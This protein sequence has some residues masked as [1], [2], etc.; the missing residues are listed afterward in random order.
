M[1]KFY[2]RLALFLVVLL[3][4]PLGAFAQI[5]PDESTLVIAQTVDVVTFEPYQSSSRPEANIYSHVW[6]TLLSV[7]PDGDII[8][9]A[10]ESYTVSDDGTEYTFT[11]REGL[12]CHDGAPL[13][14]D[15]VVFS[16]QR[17][18]DPDNGFTGN[19]AGFV[20]NSLGYRDVRLDGELQATVILNGPQ[21]VA[22]GLFAEVYLIC[23]ESYE[24]LSLEEAA[25]RPIGS[26]PYRFV[27]WVP[28]DY[29]LLERYEDFSLEPG[30]FDRLVWRVIPE[31]STRVAELLAG[32]VDIVAN[33]PPDQVTVINNSGVA[34]AQ[35][36]AGTRRI[37]VGFSFNEEA[38]GDAPGFDAIQNT[39]VRIAMN[40][41]VDVPTICETLLSFSCERANGLVNPPNHNRNIEPYPY[42]PAR[43]EEILDAAGY[44]RGEDGV[45]FSITLQAPRGRYVNDANVA[46]A[47]GQYLSDVGIDTTVELIEWAE[48]VP[49][50][51]TQTAGPLF[52]LGTGGATW[53]AIYDMA[54]LSSV[55]G[56]TNYTQ[57]SNPEWFDN[58]PIML[59]A[60]G[61]EQ[62]ALIDYML[63]VFFNDPPWL[64]L[65]FQPDFYGVSNRI[66]WEARRDEKIDVR[67]ASLAQ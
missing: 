30:N 55:T 19:I 51:R 61:D 59:A 31:A 34:E 35:V 4:L 43:A 40:M 3:A 21:P 38:F 39:D 9:Y 63:E 13:T 6:I 7:T 36:V 54:D 29:L 44:P 58:W 66:D 46:L 28:D 33:V 60:T 32:N 45:R 16:F 42:D 65:Y 53:S 41:A 62:R 8:P 22:P 20:M 64:M 25:Q 56:S 26:G 10:A 27:E 14:A 52:F 47:I 23:R 37:Y 18:N 57:W 1:T 17:A 50:I 5:A 48:Y 24:P 11:L 67:D 15:D 2:R 49:L 12:T